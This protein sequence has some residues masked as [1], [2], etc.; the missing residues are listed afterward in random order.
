MFLAVLVRR[1]LPPARALAAAGALGVL[2]VGVGQ[3]SQT[4]GVLRTTASA[5]TVISATIPLLVV[6]FAALRLRQPVATRQ[7]VGL[8]VAFGGI[9][10]VV[11][12]TPDRTAPVFAA[13]SLIGDALVLL[14]AVAVALY[15][16]LSTE[17]AA[18]YSVTTVAALTSLAGAGAVTPIAA[19]TWPSS[20]PHWGSG[21]GS[22]RCAASRPARRRLS[23]TSNPWSASRP[24]PPCL[25]T[26]SACGSGPAR[27]WC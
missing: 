7:A 10:C 12:G 16:V 11:I 25:V 23:N 17:L 19:S 24:P 20:S 18:R 6:V 26:V 22:M 1:P 8:V 14:S 4:L 2:G 9:G 13:A 21:C 15:Y 3:V 5:A 27:R